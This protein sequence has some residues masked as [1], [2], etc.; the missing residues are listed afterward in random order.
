MRRALLLCVLVVIAGARGKNETESKERDE[1]AI[2]HVYSAYGS[3][4]YNNHPNDTSISNYAP[5]P[6]TPTPA[7]QTPPTFFDYP[8]Q[9]PSQTQHPPHP[10]PPTPPPTPPA[11]SPAPYSY[12]GQN[13]YYN[14]NPPPTPAPT[15]HVPYDFG[16]LPPVQPPTPTT[17]NTLLPTTV[18]VPPGST[19]TFTTDP[20]A[21]T[22][23]PTHT[24]VPCEFCDYACWAAHGYTKK[25]TPC[26]KLRISL[27]GLS[28]LFVL[29][30]AMCWLGRLSLF[31][32]ARILYI[33]SSLRTRAHALDGVE[34]ETSGAS[35]ST[36][37]AHRR[38]QVD[39]PRAIDLGRV[40][41]ELARP[42]SIYDV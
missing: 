6:E 19:V 7:P 41:E 9:V 33:G 27:V 20:S 23:V 24:P 31:K 3:Y 28:I 32:R 5:T 11:P 39:R 37:T 40:T 25:K 29:M 34:Y 8:Y 15:P 21:T 30:I 2:T 18:L 36:T 14:G 10:K 38:A 35:A 26:Y 42:N 22:P 4:H 17:L 12:S 1:R 16:P 13:Y